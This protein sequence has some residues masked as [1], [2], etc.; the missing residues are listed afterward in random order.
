MYFQLFILGSSQNV[1]IE[2]IDLESL[3]SDTNSL[4]DDKWLFKDGIQCLALAI[5]E[6]LFFETSVIMILK[7]QQLSLQV[8]TGEELKSFSFSF[9]RWIILEDDW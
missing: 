5:D 4:M 9:W 6:S 8:W 2:G 7:R 3:L 1:N